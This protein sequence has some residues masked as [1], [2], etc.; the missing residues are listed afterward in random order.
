MLLHNTFLTIFEDALAT[1]SCGKRIL[2]V[3]MSICFPAAVVEG[4]KGF[5][6]GT[7]GRRKVVS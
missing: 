5:G 7:E 3:F 2:E 4:L 6:Y 1:N